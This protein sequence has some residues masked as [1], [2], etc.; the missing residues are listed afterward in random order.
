MMSS[1]Y[2][3]F[4]YSLLFSL[5]FVKVMLSCV[6]HPL[7]PCSTQD[8]S[9]AYDVLLPCQEQ[10]LRAMEEQQRL[11]KS[12]AE[13]QTVQRQ[14]EQQL[15]EERSKVNHNFTAH[16]VSWIRRY[17]NAVYGKG[18][19]LIHQHFNFDDLHT[20]TVKLPRQT[21][22]TNHPLNPPTHPT[23]IQGEQGY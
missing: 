7:Y 8:V 18:L 17:W 20:G 11:V 21:F 15:E 16:P 9:H 4:G 14:L 19:F 2:L 13:Y 1:V 22:R 6:L 3:S 23:H 10:L 5:S 12:V